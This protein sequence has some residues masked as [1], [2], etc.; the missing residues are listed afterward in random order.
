LSELH[1]FLGFKAG[2]TNFPHGVAPLFHEHFFPNASRNEKFFL[3]ATGRTQVLV[4]VDLD[5]DL[6][7]VVLPAE[8]NGRTFRD[9]RVVNKRSMVLANVDVAKADTYRR[10]AELVVRRRVIVLEAATEIGDGRT[11]QV[12]RREPDTD[13]ETVLVDSWGPNAVRK[14]P[15]R[16]VLLHLS[17]RMKGFFLRLNDVVVIHL[18]KRI[19]IWISLVGWFVAIKGM[20]FEIANFSHMRVVQAGV[21]ALASNHELV[22]HVVEEGACT[23]SMFH[24]GMLV[25]VKGRMVFVGSDGRGELLSG[26]RGFA[27]FVFVTRRELA[28]MQGGGRRKEKH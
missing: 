11:A 23:P 13:I 24:Q 4:F 6:V 27:L 20:P 9:G 1:D 26:K 17:R 5:L 7:G 22:L 21:L 25:P 14:D 19:V 28:L 16:S 8:T 12:A 18:R 15:F 3:H 10:I 2:L